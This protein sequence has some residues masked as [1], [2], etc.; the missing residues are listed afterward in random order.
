M[1]TDRPFLRSFV[2][3]TILCVILVSWVA[4]GDRKNLE[5]VRG[6]LPG[7]FVVIGLTAGIWG[8]FSA[9]TWTWRRFAATV[10]GFFLVYIIAMCAFISFRAALAWQ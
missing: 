10:F 4:V 7:L 8:F 3:A 9:M 1:R 6:F 2:C 5:M